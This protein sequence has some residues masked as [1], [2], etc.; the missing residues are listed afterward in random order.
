VEQHFR[1]L[2]LRGKESPMSSV[3]TNHF[4]NLGLPIPS[5]AAGATG[6]PTSHAAGEADIRWDRVKA[7]QEKIASGEYDS[8]SVL[9][10]ALDKMFDDLI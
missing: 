3:A 5:A 9:D 4:P 1:T 2:E 10:A 7:A 8:G 6:G